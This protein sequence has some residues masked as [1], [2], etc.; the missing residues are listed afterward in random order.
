MNN[1]NSLKCGQVYK[2]RSSVD[3]GNVEE[4]DSAARR[5]E[6]DEIKKKVQLPFVDPH[7]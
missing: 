6:V 1:K 4:V 7:G 5:R 2:S 3:V